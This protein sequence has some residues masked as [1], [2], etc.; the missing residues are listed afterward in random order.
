[1]KPFKNKNAKQLTSYVANKIRIIIS[2][3]LIS[4]TEDRVFQAE[5]YSK[6]R[7]KS[8]DQVKGYITAF[9]QTATYKDVSSLYKLVNEKFPEHKDYVSKLILLK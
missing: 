1:M 8:S 6:L 7:G 3:N 4:E 9:I 5:I 2:D